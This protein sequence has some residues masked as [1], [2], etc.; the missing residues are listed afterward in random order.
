M[1]I[2]TIRDDH[3]ALHDEMVSRKARHEA[4]THEPFSAWQTVLDVGYEWWQSHP[5]EAG[6]T[7]ADMIDHMGGEYGEFAA[8]LVLL[9]KANC[10]ICNGGVS[11]Y[12]DNGFASAGARGC[13]S[14]KDD[15]ELHHRLVA[16]FGKYLRGAN[17]KTEM[18]HTSP[19]KKWHL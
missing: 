2:K 6:I 4:E 18:L 15:L 7:Y 10:Q 5:K 17:R 12:F 14:K 8:L 9:G 16:L 19:L 3:Q 13:F 1:D 11:Q